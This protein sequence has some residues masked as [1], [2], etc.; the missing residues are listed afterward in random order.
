M[1]ALSQ[2]SGLVVLG[3][4]IPLMPRATPTVADLQW[5][6]AAGLAG[7][8]GVALLYRALAIGTMGVVAPVTAVCAVAIPVVAS[9]FAGEFPS[10]LAGAGIGLALV[11]IVLVAQEDRGAAFEP[12]APRPHVLPPGVLIALLSGVAI[13]VFFLLLAR[14]EREAGLWPL[15]GSRSVSLV[16]FVAAALA[17]RRPLRLPLGDALTCAGCGV[18]DTAANVLYL[19]ASREGSLPLVV[20]LSSMY[21]ASTVLLARIV[22]GERLSRLQMAG[23]YCALLAVAL[24]VRG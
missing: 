9:M 18:L 10:R 23:L 20:T 17:L 11:A 21:P 24:I 2:I 3:L 13:G 7:T 4:V 8:V 19:L 1:V 12:G 6:I 5:G 14:T 22:L 15:V 16:C